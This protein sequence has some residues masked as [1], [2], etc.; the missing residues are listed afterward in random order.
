MILQWH[1]FINV[2]HGLLTV[3]PLYSYTNTPKMRKLSFIL[4]VLS[5]SACGYAQIPTDSL[6][7]LYDLRFTSSERELMQKDLGEQ[8]KD[9][10]LLHKFSLENSVMPAI[11]FNPIPMGFQWPSEEAP[12]SISL[13]EEVELPKNK[14]ELAFYTVAQLATLIQKREVTSVELTNIYLRPPEKIWRSASLCGK[15]YRRPGYGASETS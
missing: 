15:P 8:Q 13:D 10:E 7:Q 2:D 1:L 6:E 3:Y 5:L 4:L 9:Y 11:Q 14:E 12:I